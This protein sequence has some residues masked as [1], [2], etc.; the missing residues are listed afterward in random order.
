[1]NKV[2]E[3]IEKNIEKLN[4]DAKAK[5]ALYQIQTIARLDA[6]YR[7]QL[8]PNLLLVSP[9]GAGTTEYGKVY[10]RI[11]DENHIYDIRGLSTFLELD[12]PC[13][14]SPRKY[15]LFFSSP[16]VVASTQN[17][18]YGTFLLSFSR[19]EGRDLFTNPYFDTLLEFIEQNRDNMQF[20]FHVRPE[21]TE[22]EKLEMSLNRILHMVRVEF[23]HP[24]LEM[25]TEYVWTRL[26]DVG[27]SLPNTYKEKFKTA[28]SG[29]LEQTEFDGYS[30]LEL[31]ARRIQYELFL[32]GIGNVD[33]ECFEKTVDKALPD[34]KL[35]EGN[36]VGFC[37][38]GGGR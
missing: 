4:I 9:S 38:S 22:K 32:V 34:I 2:Q 28:L 21:F 31:I 14:D 13:D 25:S 24:N 18:F 23:D 36:S 26:A 35:S 20:I 17:N 30:S 19:F 1:M 37:I 7:K 33:M 6:P 16:R 5:T 10:S 11:I 29:W 15:N 12:F 8:V 3:S 27:I